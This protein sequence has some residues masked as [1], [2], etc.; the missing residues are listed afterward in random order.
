M[1]IPFDELR[2]GLEE[3]LFRLRQE[4]AQLGAQAPEGIGY[5]DHMA[6]DA[7]DAMD[8]TM[9]AT[10]RRRLEI[11]IREVEAAL[12]RME[13]GTYGICVTCGRPIDV[14]R[15]KAIPFAALCLECQSKHER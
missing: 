15:L 13:E 2:R 7:T 9:Q 3:E 12:K 8:Q 4:L 11:R 1:A 6:D 10:L 14:A 5:H